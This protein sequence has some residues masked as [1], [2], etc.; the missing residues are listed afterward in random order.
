MQFLHLNE[1]ENDKRGTNQANKET[2]ENSEG[3]SRFGN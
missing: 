2:K 1:K 3:G